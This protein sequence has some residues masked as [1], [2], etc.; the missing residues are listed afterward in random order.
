MKMPIRTEKCWACSKFL[1]GGHFCPH[2]GK[3][4]PLREGENYFGFLGI[5]ERLTIDFEFL[6]NRF[7]SLSRKFHPDFYQGRSAEEKKFSLDKASFLNKAYQTLRVP[8]K[9]AVYLFDLEGID[10]GKDTKA[11]P[12]LLS[13]VFEIQERVTDQRGRGN[14]AIEIDPELKNV[15][16]DFR[17]RLGNFEEQM[18]LL[19]LEWDSGA[20]G[21]SG[22][23]G[24]EKSPI[25]GK[26]RRLIEDKKYIEE[27]LRTLAGKNETGG[28]NY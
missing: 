5:P 22:G 8:E 28:G 6:R 13:K 11:S 2:C 10:P 1:E 3:I 12:E 24:K 9:R 14:A 18:R 20:S 25:A 15:E 27:A 16:E 21:I 19:F 17:N 4:Q 7:Y 23:D 26:I